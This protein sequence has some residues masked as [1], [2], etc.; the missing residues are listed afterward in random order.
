MSNLLIGARLA[1]LERLDGIALS[2]AEAV[3][4]VIAGVATRHD[5]NIYYQAYSSEWRDG[6]VDF[7]IEVKGAPNTW[8]VGAHAPDLTAGELMILLLLEPAG[9]A[10]EQHLRARLAE[11]F[12]RDRDLDQVPRRGL[13]R[14]ATWILI[15]DMLQRIWERE[16]A[17]MRD[18]VHGGQNRTQPDPAEMAQTR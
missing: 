18:L 2:P 15:D 10:D 8:P 1:R 6:L 13:R 3:D 7:A 11:D 17:E 16:E 12:G 14:A 9:T 4:H 5:F